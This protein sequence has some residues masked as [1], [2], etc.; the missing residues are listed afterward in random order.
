[1]KQLLV[2]ID[3]SSLTM[4]LQHLSLIELSALSLTN[5]YYSE[6][7]YQYLYQMLFDRSVQVNAMK[8]SQFKFQQQSQQQQQLIAI[9][10][11]LHE[12]KQ[13]VL[14]TMKKI[15]CDKSLLCINVSASFDFLL[16]Q[17]GQVASE[18]HL[19]LLIPKL[20]PLARLI[21]KHAYCL[22]TPVFGQIGTPEINVLEYLEPCLNPRSLSIITDPSLRQPNTVMGWTVTDPANPPPIT[23]EVL[24]EILIQIMPAITLYKCAGSNG[25]VM[26]GGIQIKEAKCSILQNILRQTAP[27]LGGAVPTTTNFVFGGNMDMPTTGNEVLAK[28]Q[29]LLEEVEELFQDNSEVCLLINLEILIPKFVL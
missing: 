4:I 1:M 17:H 22:T 21:G 29:K 6:R 20:Y 8:S 9:D 5:R 7:V 27:L 12:M 25:Q 26:P 19:Q 10:S 11:F 2:L 14:Y 3:S 13:Y 15:I 23:D 16:K 24:K 28:L 18:K